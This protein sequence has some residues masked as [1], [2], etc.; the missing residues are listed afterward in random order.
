[1]YSPHPRFIL[2]SHSYI[3]DR[4][5]KKNVV[6]K[7]GKSWKDQTF[8][9]ITPPETEY[10]NWILDKADW[11]YFRDNLNI[12]LTKSFSNTTQMSHYITSTIISTHRIQPHSSD[13]TAEHRETRGP[14]VE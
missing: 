6:N 13:Q 5:I 9:T 2:I 14:F 12:S 4:F 7:N 8:S 1:M 11:Q 10:L 3:L